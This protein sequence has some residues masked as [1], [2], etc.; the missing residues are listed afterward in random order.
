MIIKDRQYLEHTDVLFCD[1][2]GKETFHYMSTEDLPS[3][4][5]KNTPWTHNPEG[6][7]ALVCMDCYDRHRDFNYFRLIVGMG[8]CHYCHREIGSGGG[9]CL[10]CGRV[11]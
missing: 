7:K 4:F 6:R 3:M 9:T 8:W 10:Y 2:C 5:K 1:I 11:N